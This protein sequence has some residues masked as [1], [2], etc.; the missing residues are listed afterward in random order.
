MNIKTAVFFTL[1]ATLLTGCAS[2]ISQSNWAVAIKST[3]DTA[4]FSIT[5]QNGDKIHSGTTPATVNLAS[6]A[7]YFDGEKYTLSFSK[8]GFQ[9]TTATLDT[10]LN[11]WYFGNLVFGGILGILVI[12]PATGAMFKLPPEFSAVLPAKL[13]SLEN[14]ASDI[15]VLSLNDVPEELRAQLVPVH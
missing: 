2:I 15:S 9:D 6:G 7:G 10:S 5:N 12:D 13:S 3:P 4:N 11:G 14:S 1:S 8:P